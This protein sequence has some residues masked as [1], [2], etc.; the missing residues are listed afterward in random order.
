MTN[1]LEL[2]EITKKVTHSELIKIS[3]RWLRRKNENIKVPNCSLILE[4]Q[5]TTCSSGE[6]PDVLGFNYLTSVMIEVKVSR[7]DFLRDKKK[8]FRVK[9]EMGMGKLRFFC[10]PKGIIKVSE[11]PEKWG[12]LELNDDK[13][14]DLIKNATPQEADHSCEVTMLLSKIRR[15]DKDIKDLK[16]DFFN[17]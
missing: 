10:A 15:M 16:K 11:V 13:K 1:N 9:P 14:I 17:E 5:V 2:E 3:A 6:V 8:I 12:L 7:A 4:D